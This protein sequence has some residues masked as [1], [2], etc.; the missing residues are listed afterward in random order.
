MYIPDVVNC[1]SVIANN[2]KAV[3]EFRSTVTVFGFYLNSDLQ[4]RSLDFI[5]YIQDI[6]HCKP[7]CT[8]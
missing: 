7:I 8:S 1:R 2:V 6:I 4:C 3:L 5:I